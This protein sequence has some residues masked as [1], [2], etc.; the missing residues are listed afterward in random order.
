[1]DPPARVYIAAARFSSSASATVAR[2]EGR[3]FG[4]LPEGRSWPPVDGKRVL[5]IFFAFATVRR[6]KFGWFGRVVRRGGARKYLSVR[7]KFEGS[8]FFWVLSLRVYS[9]DLVVVFVGFGVK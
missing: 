1:M 8:I 4:E 6:G 7:E 9:L 3:I 5:G 2:G